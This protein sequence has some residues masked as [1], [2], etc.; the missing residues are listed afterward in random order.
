MG[1]T[2]PEIDARLAEFLTSQPVFFVGSAPAGRDG[3]VNCSPKGGEG[4]F[5]VLGPHQVAYQDFTG[6]GAETLAHLRENGRIVVMFCAFSGPPRIVRLHGRGRAVTSG[7]DEFDRLADKFP[8][9][10]SRRAF[11]VVDVERVSSSCGYGVPLMTF[12]G[13]RDNMLKWADSKGPDGL[14]KYRE[15]NNA[16]SLDGLPALAGDP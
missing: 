5:Q 13:H 4:A 9:F 1:R 7:V 6:S 15:E 16:V 8:S 2:Y 12:E 3:H 11:I 14:V 10:P